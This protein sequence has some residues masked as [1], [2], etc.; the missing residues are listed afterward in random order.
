MKKSL[1]E[2]LERIHT[3][4]YG[5]EL[6]SEQSLL[7][8]ILGKIT[9]KGADDKE[10]KKIDDPKKADLVSSDVQQFFDTLKKAAD[11]GGI[12]QQE[13]GSMNFQ[14]E[15]ESMQIGL[16]ILGYQLPRF[17]VD[18]LYGR[19]TAAAVEKFK[20][21]NDVKDGAETLGEA[22][23]QLK[24]ISYPNLK[25]DF[26]G[27]QNDFVN[28]GLLDDLNKAAGA[29]GLVA[30]ITTAKTGHGYFTKSKNKSRHM[31]G[32]GVDIAILDGVGAGGATSSTNGNAK[33]RELG[34]RLASALE[35]LGYRR[36]VESGN[37]KAVL[38][39][40][41]TGGN[42]FNHLH[43]SNKVGASELP[44]SVSDSGSV[45]NSKATP[46]MLN[47]L[48]ELLKTKGVKSEDLKKYIDTTFISGGGVDSNW[49]TITQKV[50][51]TFEGGYWNYW[52]CKNHPYDSIYN[53]SGETLFGLDRKAGK[54][55][56]ISAE[57]RE[58]FKIIDEEKQRLGMDKFCQ[59]WK[60]NYRG[61]PLEGRLK[62]LA[63]KVMK[64]LYDQNMSN[65]VK[66]SEVKKRIEGNPGL[67][68]HMSYACWNG[69][70]FFQKFA[71]KLE[72]GVNNGLSDEELIQLVT[73]QREELIAGGWTKA[74]T[75]V[76]NTIRQLS[77]VS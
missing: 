7:D 33:F 8:K 14:K 41:N 70:G 22:M 42:H 21:D 26:D 44:A 10:G 15:V 38:W 53:K 4:T 5:K 72:E 77:N 29:A 49:M 66:N 73:K 30:T 9:G 54:I 47:K 20:S 64:R 17:G 62:E 75:R 51:D 28:Q 55:E 57:G 45:S 63:A 74:T 34:N 13:M 65:Y 43:V 67:L 40:T 3:L 50:I 32:T 48:I 27:T 37:D 39:Q 36:N 1:I 6:L 31:D 19:E 71:N 68:L 18:G 23:T 24:T 60:Y 46:E 59:V 69:P 61:G 35:S 2:E 56:N 52:E 76:N 16:M 11:G 12:S 25:I 58:F